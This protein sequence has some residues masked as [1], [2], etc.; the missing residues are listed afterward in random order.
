M[1][2]KAIPDDWSLSG[3]LA[4]AGWSGKWLYKWRW[5]MLFLTPNQ[6]CQSSTEGSN[7]ALFDAKC[8]GS[9]SA[10]WWN[11]CVATY[12]RNDIRWTI[13]RSQAVVCSWQKQQTQSINSLSVLLPSVLF[14]FSA[15]TLLVG[16]QE[17]QPA[18]KN[19]VMR[20]WCG[21]LSGTRCRLFEYGP[22]DAMPSQY[23]II[24]CLI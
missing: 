19:W 6:Q 9:Y 22:A 5:W 15:L 20:C 23:P 12:R 18:C 16:R 17:E 13:W 7:K 14:A 8:N 1:F 11:N 3:K 10:N 2:R 21:Y 24:S 4:N